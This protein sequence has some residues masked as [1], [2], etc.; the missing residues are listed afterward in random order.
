MRAR[1]WAWCLTGMALALVGGCGE[2]EADGSD[3]FIADLCAELAP[4]C[5]R[6]GRPSDGAQCRA[7]YSAFVGSASFDQAA[8]DDCLAEFRASEDSC[9]LG[10]RSA[11]SCAKVFSSS[12][13]TKQPGEACDSD[14]DCASQPEGRVE[15]ASEY[16]DGANIQQC[17]LRLPGKAGSSPCIG[18]VDGNLTYYSGVQDSIPATGYLC[19]LADGLSCDSQTGACEALAALGEPCTGEC[20]PSAYCSFPDRVCTARV[21]VGEPCAPAEEC[22]EEAYCETDSGSCVARRETG[23]ACETSQECQSGNCTNQKCAA[24]S[25]LSLVLLCGTN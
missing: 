22:V 14:S 1:I 5:A 7:F 25:D 13:G 18:T 17:Q 19:D 10:S 3:Q 9:D 8:A 23:A 4:C 21:A 16:V 2:S 12:G 15:C 11:P 20:V 6:A 24:N